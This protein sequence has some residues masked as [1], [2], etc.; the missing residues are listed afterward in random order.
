M[1]EFG[2]GKNMVR[3]M[4]FWVEAA[5]MAAPDGKTGLAITPLAAAIFGPRGFDPWVED[6]QTL[7][8]IHWHIA[9][10]PDPLFA[11]Q[12]LLCQWHAPE[13]TEREAVSAFN[14]EAERL[15]KRLSLVTLQQHFQVFLHSYMPTRGAKAAVVED[16]LDCPLT[17]L[18]LVISAGEREATDSHR[19]EPVYA[20]R[21][22]PKPTISDALF[23]YCVADYWQRYYPDEETLSS[24]TIVSGLASPG[25]VFKL[26]EDDVYVRLNRMASATAGLFTFHES[27][28]LKQLRRSRAEINQEALLAGIYA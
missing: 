26:P 4:R 6:I 24:R 8:V 11:W 20:F 19:R 17:E 27:A 22:E 16:N 25:H 18:E 1:V 14:K 28:V 2:V 3:S 23:A 21:R 5:S 13:F 10:N 9:T 12:F 7:W 15:Q